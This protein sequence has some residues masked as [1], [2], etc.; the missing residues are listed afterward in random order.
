M[1]CFP[2]RGRL[3][4]CLPL[5]RSAPAPVACSRGR[6]YVYLCS[7]F[8]LYHY[9]YTSTTLMHPHPH[10]RPSC[11]FP[12]YVGRPPR[13]PRALACVPL[14]HSGPS[15]ALARHSARA[16]RGPCAADW[17]SQFK[18]GA[19]HRGRSTCLP[20]LPLGSSRCSR[21]RWMALYRLPPLDA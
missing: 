9:T 1:T 7:C 2:L 17:L 19:T 5:S 12:S 6:P 14:P 8:F 21:R 4:A 13:A 11:P 16:R 10:A 20:S 18:N 3:S 15:C